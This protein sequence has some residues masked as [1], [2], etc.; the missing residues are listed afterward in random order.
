MDRNMETSKQEHGISK[1]FIESCKILMTQHFNFV[2][3]RST[4]ERRIEELKSNGHDVK[5]LHS[6]INCFEMFD[7]ATRKTAD[8][9]LEK[10]PIW[11]YFLKHVTDLDKLTTLALIA[12]IVD[13]SRFETSVKLWAYCGMHTYK[14]EMKTQKRWFETK[15]QAINFV[16]SILT[17]K[18]SIGKK[19]E[20]EVDELLSLCVW[21]GG[22]FTKK[23]A[24]QDDMGKLENW[25]RFLK[26]ICLK[27]S[28]NFDKGSENGFYHK[29]LRSRELKEIHKM[30]DLIDDNFE[31]IWLADPHMRSNLKRQLPGGILAKANS[32]AKRETVK[33]FLSHLFHYWC[34]MNGLP[35]RRPHFNEDSEVLSYPG[36]TLEYTAV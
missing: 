9:M 18:C 24:A 32:R 1:P 27:I 33:I 23:V 5:N 19:Y 4:T 3:G 30:T 15:Q 31:S 16:E 20:D 21:G 13:I 36:V 25:N 26:N 2:V 29:I 22:Y 35:V 34:Q 6:L 17:N 8:G 10:F 28:D 11:E 14:V 12:G 7:E